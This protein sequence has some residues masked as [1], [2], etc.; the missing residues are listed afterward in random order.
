M[1]ELDRIEGFAEVNPVEGWI[2][3]FYEGGA[4]YLAVRQSVLDERMSEWFGE[5]D[6]QQKMAMWVQAGW[7][8]GPTPQAVG[9]ALHDCWLIQRSALL[10]R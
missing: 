6:A 2:G 7:V 3:R 8:G 10:G 4:P 1:S 9:G 5:A